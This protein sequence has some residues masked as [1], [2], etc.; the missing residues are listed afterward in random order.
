VAFSDRS[1]YCAPQGNG[2]EHMRQL[3]VLL[4]AVTAASLLCVATVRAAKSDDLP[5]GPDAPSLLGKAAVASPSAFDTPNAAPPLLDGSTSNAGNDI[6]VRL[7]GFFHGV[8]SHE[9]NTYDVNAS[10][11]TPRL[12][13]GVPGYLAYALP[14]LQFGGAVN[15]A[16]RTSFA[17][18]GIAMTLPITKR[19]FFEPFLGGA[20]DN[21]S[22]TP[23]PTLA[24]LGCPLLFHA[25]AS[26]GVSITEHWTA[27]GTFEHL[28]NGKELGVDCGTNEVTEGNQG[29]NNWGI[30]LDYAF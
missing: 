21:G 30:S 11:L 20:V 1:R 3:T 6:D 8:G 26:I 29:L 5:P 4:A 2:L 12:D 23:T 13:L 25:G 17:Y 10:F 16:G 14:R 24:G 7:G 19:I 27:L 9:R 18:G 22:L 28:S 15:L